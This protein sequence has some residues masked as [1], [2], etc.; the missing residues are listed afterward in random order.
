MARPKSEEKRDAIL[1]AAVQVIADQGLGA[2]TARIAG[3]AGVA[4]G[5]LFTYFATKDLLLNQLYLGLKA[6]LRQAMMATYPADAPL[7]DRLRHI[8]D[9]YVDWGVHNPAK[10]QTLAQL[11]V[12]GRLATETRALGSEGFARIEDM[13]REG[14]AQDLMREQPPDFAAAILASLAETTM[15]FI[16]RR[17]DNAENYR[18]AGFDAFWHAIGR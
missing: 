6:E 16:L 10:R 9:R 13:V 7:R 14:V 3:L 2:T 1:A 17:P 4:E 18:T 11:I 8:W 15:D 5:T 12:S